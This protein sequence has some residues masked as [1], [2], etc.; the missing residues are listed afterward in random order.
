MMTEEQLQAENKRLEEVHQKALG[1]EN[2]ERACGYVGNGTHQSIKIA[3][4]EDLSKVQVTG[5][6][7]SVTGAT[8]SEALSNYEAGVQVLDTIMIEEK[9][10]A[11][12]H[13]TELFAIAVESGQ[14]L[15]VGEDD[16]TNEFIV[17]IGREWTWGAGLMDAL[18]RA[19][20]EMKPSAPKP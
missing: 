12:D 14:E 16:A 3:M 4:T 6:K 17:S 2:L 1:Y 20:N 18:E 11:F 9:A 5:G 10:Q 7:R 19:V 15:K 8:L 13:L